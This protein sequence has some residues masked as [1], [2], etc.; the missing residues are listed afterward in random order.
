MKS[1]FTGGEL[2]L[3]TE[4]RKA[5]FRKEEY[6]YTHV[7]YQCEDTKELFTT[8][9][10]DEVNTAQ[11]Y[12]EYRF[13][14]GI[15]YPD[16]IK[17]T[18]KSYKLSA[19]KMSKILGFGDNQYRLYENGEIPNVANGKVLKAIQSPEVFRTFV[20]TA[21]TNLTPDEYKSII[22]RIDDREQQLKKEESIYDLMFRNCTGGRYNGYTKPSIGI[23][24]NVILF[25]IEK[26]NG[27]FPTKMNKLLFY[28]DFFSFRKYG[29]SITGL[30]FRAI[31]RG[32][33]P[34]NWDIIYSLIDD[35]EQVE[36]AF[37][38]T[39][40]TGYELISNIPSDKSV[41]SNEQLSVLEIVYN[42]FKDDSCKSISEK[43]HREKA[44][45]DNNK[46]H[47][48]IDYNYAFSLVS[49]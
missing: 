14:Y 40:I 22:S 33:V 43:S 32:P 15:P 9:E 13:K 46:N 16:E 27:V 21:Q 42:T 34:T 2:T 31:Q 6:E 48:L 25:F 10:L 41:F 39:N 37:D 24:K 12:N 35:I 26:C 28:T 5:T 44:W 19:L 7:C 49:I 18:R 29:H 3:F 4:K 1:P 20:D 8:T 36:I 17:D 47:S 45:L 38:G 23:L 11:I 30:S